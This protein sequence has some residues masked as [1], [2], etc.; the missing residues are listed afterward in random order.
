MKNNTNIRASEIKQWAFCPRQWYLQ[1]T[2]G[3]RSCGGPAARK[4]EEFHRNKARGVQEVRK[5]QSALTKALMIGGIV[6]LLW[7]FS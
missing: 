3:R 5:A 7:L 4:G 1:R 2:T 6:C